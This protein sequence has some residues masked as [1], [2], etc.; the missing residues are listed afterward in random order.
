MVKCAST[1]TSKCARTLN[2]TTAFLLEILVL[3]AYDDY[4][5]VSSASQAALSLFSGAYQSQQDPTTPHGTLSFAFVM[6]DLFTI[7]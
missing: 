5:Q 1:I 2:S 7:L 6:T 4:P 3:H